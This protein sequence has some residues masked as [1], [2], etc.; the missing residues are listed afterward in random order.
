VVF[1]EADLGRADFAFMAMV[2]IVKH[3]CAARKPDARR[4]VEREVGVSTRE[5][6]SKTSAEVWHHFARGRK[7]RARA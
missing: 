3:A 6:F 1:F 7:G 4:K 2:L 5:A